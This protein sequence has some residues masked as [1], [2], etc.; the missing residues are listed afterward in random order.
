VQ[1]SL[2]DRDDSA[3]DPPRFRPALSVHLSGLPGWLAILFWISR[4]KFWFAYSSMWLD[5]N[6]VLV[7]RVR[8]SL[9]ALS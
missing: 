9:Q 8:M 5:W 7:V 6:G 4:T 2:L 1:R 3:V